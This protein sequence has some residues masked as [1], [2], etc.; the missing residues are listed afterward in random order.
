MKTLILL[1]IGLAMATSAYAVDRHVT[2]TGSDSGGNTCLVG[3]PCRSIVY[4][5]SKLAS[6]ETLY[7]HAGTYNESIVNPTV[8]SG[9]ATTYTVIR[10]YGTD[11]V[12]IRPSGVSDLVVLWMDENGPSAQYRYIEFRGL[13]F[14]FSGITNYQISHILDLKGSNPQTAT[15]QPI[16]IRFINNEF[17]AQGGNT[18][19]NVMN[20]SNVHEVIG[21]Y[22]HHF[23][24]GIYAGGTFDAPQGAG[25]LI[26]GNTFESF[27]CNSGSA[28]GIHAYAG[29]STNG[30]LGG[31]IIRKNKFIGPRIGTGGC[32]AIFMAQADN[33]LITNNLISGLTGCNGIEIDGGSGTND[34]IYNNT[35]INNPGTA[36]YTSY[37][38]T[39]PII[40]N[41][42]VYGNG[43][44]ITRDTDH[45]ETYS[46]NL[47]GVAGL[48]CSIV[49]NP[50]L[51]SDG[52]L[53]AASTAA[54][55]AGVSVGIAFNGLRPDVGAFESSTVQSCTTIDSQTVD[56]QIGTAYAPFTGLSG[57]TGLTLS[58]DGVNQSLS[59]CS[60][61]GNG[62]LRYRCALAC[63]TSTSKIVAS[64]GTSGIVDAIGV[65]SPLTTVINQKLLPWNNFNVTN[66]LSGTGPTFTTKH[67]RCRVWNH[68]TSSNNADDWYRPEDTSCSVQVINGKIAIVWAI[69]CTD[70]DCPAQGFDSEYQ[71]NGGGG[72]TDITNSCANNALCYD[73]TQIGGAVHGAQLV[74]NLFNETP[75]PTYIAGGVVAQD[76]SYPIVDLSQNSFTNYLA[77]F[78]V[79]NGFSAGSTS[80]CVRPKRD[81]GQAISHDVTACFSLVETGLEAP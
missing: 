47:C 39:N 48:G 76:S 43:A 55:D 37:S 57:C 51:D 23:C 12:R 41:N 19:I 27:G 5:M 80:I 24:Y 3:S 67:F 9:T 31:Y 8:A 10:N 64:H 1:L 18:E 14:D 34:M 68:N 49:G 44:A 7:V 30:R 22:F 61:A 58:V 81:N 42:I 33:A 69:T 11:V 50:Q 59:G 62:A 29:D 17:T 38:A 52:T 45:G 63:M 36:I 54:M 25:T 15:N 71:L 2:T 20:I 70:A 46:N 6:G 78:A 60:I 75:Q 66:T 13:I 77:S 79:K 32:K 21:N 40:R 4:G 74:A 26:E 73:N 72:W 65:G 16:H 28:F 56:C 53:T 35:I